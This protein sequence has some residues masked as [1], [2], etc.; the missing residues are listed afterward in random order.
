MNITEGPRAKIEGWKERP[1]MV[2]GRPSEVE[3]GP[4]GTVRG[5]LEGGEVNLTDSGRFA[6][7]FLNTPGYRR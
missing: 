3:G 2:E 4:G 5:L 7:L 6:A 1:S